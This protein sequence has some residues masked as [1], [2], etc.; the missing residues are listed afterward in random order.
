VATGQPG[1]VA[2]DLRAVPDKP[3]P[4]EDG[5]EPAEGMNVAG[6]DSGDDNGDQAVEDVSEIGEMSEVKDSVAEGKDDAG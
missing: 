5:N 4:D 1:A 3:G 2:D 6:Q